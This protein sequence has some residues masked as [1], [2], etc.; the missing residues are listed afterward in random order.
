MLLL[1]LDH[2]KSINDRF[3]HAGGD[4]VLSRLSRLV[5]SCLEPGEILARLGGEEFVVF[6]PHGGG[7]A[8]DL[9]ETARVR[10]AEAVIEWRGDRIAVSTSVGVALASPRRS[11]GRE[12][13]LARADAALYRA[14]RLGRNRVEIDGAAL[15]DGVDRPAGIRQGVR[16]H[17]APG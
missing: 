10:L 5:E 8:A 7:R 3:G 14:K 11:E 13:L 2:F 12:A 9:A 15:S 4:A 16:P 6:L 17:F 1:D